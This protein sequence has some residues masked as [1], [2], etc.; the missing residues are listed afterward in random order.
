MLVITR[1]RGE[2]FFVNEDIEI[3]ILEASS[4]VRIGINAPCEASIAW[5]EL[6]AIDEPTKAE[7]ET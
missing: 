7:I 2:S 5:T 1:R 4:P 6:I 3:S